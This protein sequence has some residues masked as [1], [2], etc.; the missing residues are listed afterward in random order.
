MGMIRHGVH[1]RAVN[2]PG[3]RQAQNSGFEKGLDTRLQDVSSDMQMMHNSS[4]ILTKYMPRE[5]IVQV[6]HQLAC[7]R[8]N[9]GAYVCASKVGV[10]FTILFY[11]PGTVL[12]IVT[13]TL[14]YVAP[15]VLSS[16]YMDTQS[17]PPFVSS[18]DATS[19]LSKLPFWTAV[20]K[21]VVENG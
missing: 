8:V 15:R 2:F 6:A 20:D 9:F 17:V 10:V 5:H 14:N 3:V 12:D 18:V 7:T 11:C 16:A 19:I 13:A 4:P 21:H 1:S